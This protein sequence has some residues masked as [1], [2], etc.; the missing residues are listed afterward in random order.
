MYS[1]DP[2]NTGGIELASKFED[3]GKCNQQE[4]KFQQQRRF[5]RNLKQSRKTGKYIACVILEIGF[6]D[7]GR[8]FPEI[9]S[10]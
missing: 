6:S 2:S 7:S 4:H 1:E 8:S 10:P 5:I 9:R 3:Q